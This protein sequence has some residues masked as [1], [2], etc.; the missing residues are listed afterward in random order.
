MD[1]ELVEM[2]VRM[3]RENVTLSDFLLLAWAPHPSPAALPPA[4]SP[5]EW[6]WL[7]GER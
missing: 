3:F 5:L 4:P 2:P 6:T 1:K 7:K